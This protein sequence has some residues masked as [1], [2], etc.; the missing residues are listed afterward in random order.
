MLQAHGYYKGTARIWI[1]KA[2]QA[3]AAKERALASLSIDESF[4]SHHEPLTPDSGCHLSSPAES[5]KGERLIKKQRILV[6]GAY[7]KPEMVLPHQILE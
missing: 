6:G 4:S 2:L 5:P 3:K 1:P 7:A